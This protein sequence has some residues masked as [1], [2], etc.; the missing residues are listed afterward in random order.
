MAHFDPR[1]TARILIR[2]VCSTD[3]PLLAVF[4][5]SFA[6]I[7]PGTAMFWPRRL[8]AE[9][10]EMIDEYFFVQYIRKTWF[11]GCPVRSKRRYQ[12][13]HGR[14]LVLT[15]SLS[16]D[17]KSSYFNASWL[18][19]WNWR[20]TVPMTKPKVRRLNFAWQALALKLPCTLLPRMAKQPQ[21]SKHF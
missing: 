21:R 2:I 13:Q 10:N 1:P 20:D 6:P 11:A 14:R 18:K 9:Q 4:R 7:S 3:S 17:A 19:I 5:T 12:M 16:T 15:Y 8:S